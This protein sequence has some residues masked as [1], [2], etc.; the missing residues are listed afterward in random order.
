[1]LSSLIGVLMTIPQM[2]QSKIGFLFDCW[3]ARLGPG[4]ILNMT[5]KGRV[6]GK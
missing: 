5:K 6:H 3:L 2:R 1:M 4:A